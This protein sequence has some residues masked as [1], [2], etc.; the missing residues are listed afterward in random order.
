MGQ[1][2]IVSATPRFFQEIVHAPG[3]SSEFGALPDLAA[4]L[5]SRR[6]LVGAS[7]VFAMVYW[8]TVQ[9]Q[10]VEQ[11]AWS[12]INWRGDADA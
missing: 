2:R 8:N 12:S 9:R 3:S 10:M 7:S 5:T 4:S 6:W 1:R 11:D